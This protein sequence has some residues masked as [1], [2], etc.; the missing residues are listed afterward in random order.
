MTADNSVHLVS[1]PIPCRVPVT[2]I[3]PTPLAESQDKNQGQVQASVPAAALDTLKV[4]ALPGSIYDSEQPTDNV[5]VKGQMHATY[6]RHALAPAA[7]CS[8][9]YCTVTCECLLSKHAHC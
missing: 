8:L 2:V 3:K 4:P 9:Q 5:S 7:A 6:L 1:L